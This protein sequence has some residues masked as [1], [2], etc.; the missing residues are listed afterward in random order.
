[1][2]KRDWNGNIIDVGISTL[3]SDKMGIIEN[4]EM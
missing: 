3:L 1:M 2:I 4:I